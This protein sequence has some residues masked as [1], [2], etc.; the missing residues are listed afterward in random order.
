MGSVYAGLLADAGNEVWAVDPW[1][2]HLE[3]I[4]A[5]GLRVEGASGDRVV[6]G[7][8]VA[9]DP[10]ELPVVELVII[11]TK[12]SAVGEAARALA[13]CLGPETLIL[14]IQNGL[15]AGERIG[16]FMDTRNV[17]LGVADGFGA[18]MTGP[19]H[20]H[21][22]AMKLIR[23][24]EMGGGLTPRLEALA[25]LWQAAGF[26]VKA[27]AD[28]NQLIWEKFL[29]NVTLS[30]YYA[31]IRRN[32]DDGVLEMRSLQGIGSC[33]IVNSTDPSAVVITFSFRLDSMISVGDKMYRQTGGGLALVGDITNVTGRT[34]TVNT[35]VSGG[36][37]PLAGVFLAYIKNNVAESYGTT[38]YYM[39]YDL[40][41]PT[42][43]SSVT[44]EIYAIGSSLFK[45]F[46]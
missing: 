44:T 35:T 45:S 12:A 31:H 21:H 27:F 17:I 37:I 38:G 11:A 24:G 23:I 22:N 40:E 18:S 4:A 8:H 29:C 16:Q 9:R 33:E 20:V 30:Y 42:S 6:T 13:P 7:I 14:T 2:D 25:A 5:R 1:Q 41:L 15:G 46:P 36:S 43:V 26:N 34:I 39:Q 19:G 10:A 28:I 3:A 32:E